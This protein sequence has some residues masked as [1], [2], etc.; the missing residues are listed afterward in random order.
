[1]KVQHSLAAKAPQSITS[2]PASPE[3]DRRR[4]MK[5]YTIAMSVRMVCVICCFF[6]QGWW[7]LLPVL[8]AIILPYFAVVAANTIDSTASKSTKIVPPAGVLV[9]IDPRESKL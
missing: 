3:D 1:M 4:R 7:L 5:Q 9:V 6:A 2:L 8:G